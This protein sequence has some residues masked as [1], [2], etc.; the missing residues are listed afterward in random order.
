MP[1]VPDPVIPLTPPAA[2]DAPAIV[3]WPAAIAAPVVP[4]AVRSRVI[5]AVPVAASL[6]VGAGTSY[7]TFTTAPGPGGDTCSVEITDPIANSAVLEIHGGLT[8]FNPE[9]ETPLPHQHLSIVQGASCRLALWGGSDLALAGWNGYVYYAGQVLN[10]PAWSSDGTLVSSETNTIIRRLAV[11]LWQICRKAPANH[12]KYYLFNF[13]VYSDEEI[14]VGLVGWNISEVDHQGGYPSNW[15]TFIPMV[16]SRNA[17]ASQIV[18]AV[19][20]GNCQIT[21]ICDSDGSDPI[22]AASGTLSGGSGLDAPPAVFADYGG[23][24]AAPGKVIP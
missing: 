24:P 23:H 10:S 1:T 16:E 7:I 15:S 19:N 2:P 13:Q 9:L 12:M 3:R 6:T 5:P 18:K 20:S 22:G 21:A 17:S 14:P 4:P 8:A 11:G